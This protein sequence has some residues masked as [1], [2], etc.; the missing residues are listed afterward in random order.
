[1]TLLDSFHPDPDGAALAEGAARWLAQAYRPDPTGFS[2]EHWAAMAAS[3]WTA[4][5]LPDGA[6]GLALSLAACLPLVAEL[7]AAGLREPVIETALVAAPLA[8]RAGVD[9]ALLGDL[10][11]GR[12]ILVLM[13]DPAL[14]VAGGA[15]VTDLLV[16]DPAAETLRLCPASDVPGDVWQGMDGRCMADRALPAGGLT[17]L[18]GAE[19]RAA[20]AV[21]RAERLACLAA[22]GCGAMG[23]ALALT[24]RYLSERQQFGK[25]LAQFQVLQHRLADM[26]VERELS[27][28]MAAILVPGAAPPPAAMQDRAVAHLARALRLV[29]E[30]AIQL[31]GGMGMTD[32]MEI[33]RVFKRMLHLAT[34]LGGE[35]APR[36][37]IT[38]ALQARIDEET[39]A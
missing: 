16:F 23:R 7:G 32:E 25:P 22:E 31:H 3:G 36:N 12:R 1:M 35:S 15:E 4:L 5:R 37:R 13:D 17:L 28:S 30:A 20:V 10:A 24:A 6:G 9:P 38:R 26:L 27:Q 29:G 21:A 34:A 11:E 14:P 39:T 33:G 2:S 8:A 19:A 18:A